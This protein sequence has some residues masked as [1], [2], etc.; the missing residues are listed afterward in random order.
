LISL[1][2]RLI[3]LPPT[4][5]EIPKYDVPA[6]ILVV[7]IFIIY[8]KQEGLGYGTKIRSYFKNINLNVFLASRN[9]PDIIL[10]MPYQP[11]IDFKFSENF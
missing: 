2:L 9:S 8:G 10:G 3:I 11:E 7:N 1:L 5:H 4:N 6:K